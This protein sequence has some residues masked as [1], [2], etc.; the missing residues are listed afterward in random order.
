MRSRV[1]YVAIVIVMIAC[2]S[3]PSVPLVDAETNGITINSYVIDVEVDYKTFDFV[4]T[5]TGKLRS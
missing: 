5:C 1:A 2:L 3:I 4:S